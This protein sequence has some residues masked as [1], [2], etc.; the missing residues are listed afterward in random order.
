MTTRTASFLH[1]TGRLLAVLAAGLWFV[2]LLAPGASATSRPTVA[3][4]H[5]ET[6]SCPAGASCDTI[7]ADCPSG[8][9]CPEIIISPATNLGQNQ[10]VFL[11]AKHFPPGAIIYVYYCSDIYTLAQQDPLC[12]LQ[13]TPELLN[14]QIG[15]TASPS[16]SASISFET[17]EN[18]ND[19]NTALV[20]K[21]PGTQTTGSFYCDDDPDP[22]SI[23][24]TDPLLDSNGTVNLVLNPNNAVAVPITFQKPTGGCP[25]ATFVSTASEFGIDRL[26]PIA[27]QFDCVG[28]GKG[29]A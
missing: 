24:V 21:I 22:C 13:P 29:S 10:W 23:D 28:D 27:S 25:L 8:T 4:P 6:S 15:L 19:G 9:I 14:P 5:S 11:T 2:V 18:A 20:G 12:M 1:T 16:G 3:A 7:P 17:E 26:F